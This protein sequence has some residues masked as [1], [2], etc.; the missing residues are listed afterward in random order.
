MTTKSSFFAKKTE[1]EGERR[2]KQAKPFSVGAFFFVPS[3]SGFFLSFFFRSEPNN[4]GGP[5]KK[6]KKKRSQRREGGKEGRKSSDQEGS[7]IRK[8]RR[9]AYCVFLRAVVVLQTRNS[10]SPRSKR[11]RSRLGGK[12]KSARTN[13]ETP[14]IRCAMG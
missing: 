5:R 8:Q 7:T 3:F 11:E 6:R 12:S 9:F 10:N 2:G 1:G 13:S 4:K 14:F